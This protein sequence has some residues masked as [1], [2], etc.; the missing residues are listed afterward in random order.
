VPAL[1][2][3]AIDQH[4]SVAVVVRDGLHPHLVPRLTSVGAAELASINTVLASV[5]I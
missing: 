3:H 1:Y 2:S 5:V 4:I